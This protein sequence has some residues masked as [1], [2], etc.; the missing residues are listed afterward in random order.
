MLTVVYKTSDYVRILPWWGTFVM[1]YGILTEKVKNT[2][3]WV[4]IL[5]AG[6][7]ASLSFSPDTLFHNGPQAL[8]LV[9]LCTFALQ[10]YYTKRKDILLHKLDVA[11][12]EIKTLR[13]MLPICSTCKKIRDDQG[14]W[15]RIE[16]YI[17]EHSDAEFT[18]SNCPDCIRKLYPEMADEILKEMNSQ[19]S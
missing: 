12:S 10:H 6:A 15:N 3:V 16:S 1:A 19:S 8:T 14:V 17:S 5:Y 4:L 2:V 9:F 11:L 7:M 18:H 13:G